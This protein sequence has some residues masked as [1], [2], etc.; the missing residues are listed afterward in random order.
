MADGSKHLAKP[1][2]LDLVE[3][4]DYSSDEDSTFEDASLEGSD[5]DDNY[6]SHFKFFKAHSLA[7]EVVE[8][9]NQPSVKEQVSGKMIS[10]LGKLPQSP[11]SQ[12]LNN[13][14]F[15]DVVTKNESRDVASPPTRRICLTLRDKP[16]FRLY[17]QSE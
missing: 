9:R 7:L 6:D 11:L 8:A 5:P 1:I 17:R 15:S 2:L 10:R 14:Y 12:L 4:K 3:V 16:S 13:G